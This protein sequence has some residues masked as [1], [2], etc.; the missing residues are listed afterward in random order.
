MGQG[1][2]AGMPITPKPLVETDIVTTRFPKDL[3]GDLDA[4]CRYLGGASDRAYVIIEAVRQAMAKDRRY[5]RS[6]RA[7]AA[8]AAARGRSTDTRPPATPGQSGV[9]AK[10]GGAQDSKSHG[11][12]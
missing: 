12:A 6:L 4:Y 11:T 5:Q 8:P 10:H 7:A 3:L 9:A 2:H 1:G